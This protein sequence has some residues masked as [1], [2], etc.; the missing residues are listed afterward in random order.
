MSQRILVLA[1]VFN[2]LIF[3][4]AKNLELMLSCI[5]L[6]RNESIIII[7]IFIMFCI[8]TFFFLYTFDIEIE[9]CLL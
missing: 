9:M 1:L 6:V 3:H 2:L 8:D 5:G 4:V 7:D